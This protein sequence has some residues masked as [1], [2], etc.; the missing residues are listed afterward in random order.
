MAA[1]RRKDSGGV[2]SR[3]SSGMTSLAGITTAIAT[4]TASTTA[5]LGVAVH[6][7]ATQLD[8]AHQIV[9]VQRQQIHELRTQTAPQAT[10]SP[11]PTGT[12]GGASTGSVAHYF[13]KMNPT[14]NNALV[15]TG[16]Q[17]IAAQPY[18]NSISF[19]CDGGDG[20]QPDEAYNVAGN[21]MFTAEV[22]IADNS[23]DATN[24]IATVTFSNESGMQ[25]GQP[26]EVSLGHPI[27]LS[28]DIGGVTQLGMTCNGRD[29]RTSQN[30]NGFN[31]TLGDA[32]DS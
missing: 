5:I 22:G 6:R 7:Q 21:R 31:V 28:L 4:I 11:T 16:Q 23:E 15:E 1:S 19:G 12:T 10:N 29:R 18:V 8:Q 3:I 27:K 26:V 32:G 30:A 20:D 17:V 13:S 25:I 24:V 9:S 14:V 2:L